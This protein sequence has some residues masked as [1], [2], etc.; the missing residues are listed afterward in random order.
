MTGAYG[1]FPKIIEKELTAMQRVA[2]Y[3]R[4]STDKNDQ[5]N[6]L[7]SQK[8]YFSEYIRQN[9]MW[10]LTE[11]YVDEGIT[12]TSTKRRRAFN[13]M[14]A[15][16]ENR[17][18]DLLLTKEISRFAR[19]TLD[20]IYY[21][22]RL[23]DWGVG[24]IFL[25]DNINTLDPD[26]ELRLTI[27]S[28]IA[29]EESRKTS[30]R[31]KWGQ[32]RRMEQ[33]VVFGRSLLGY[34]VKNGKISVNEAGAD[35]VRQIYHKF[36]VE[37]KSANRIARELQ[38]AGVPTFHDVKRWSGT[39]ILRALRNEKYCGDLVQKKTFTPDYLT[40]EK[41]RNRGEEEL[42]ILRGHH[43][44]IVSRELWERAQ[45]ELA[46]R[47][48]LR[49]QR[50]RFSSRYCFSGKLRCG[51]CGAPFVPRAKRRKDGSVYRAWRCQEAAAHGKPKTDPAGNPTGCN[52]RQ[53]GHEE[54]LE[55]M[56]R[57]VGS[58]PLD[59][60]SV[61]RD[62]FKTIRTALPLSEKSEAAE[63]LQNRMRRIADKKQR[64]ID[65]YLAGEISRSDYLCLLDQYERELSESAADLERCGRSAPPDGKG[66]FLKS[67]DAP[68]R[69]MLGGELPD[70]AFFRVLL[71]RIVLYGR[72]R[73]EI[74]LKSLPLPLTAV[75]CGKPA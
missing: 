48:P 61:L 44:P 55:L 39:V 1:R 40:H 60:E 13:R 34:D 18:F 15:D 47:S 28:S 57:A 8:R 5:I 52:N 24:V 16:A 64:L 10:Q 37:Q 11:I 27:M 29:Q 74:S 72:D 53:I 31:V 3:C 62:L 68:L 38:E 58:L 69:E 54:L 17:R 63:T 30:D 51:L 32:K 66:N 19:N 46:L 41:K 59:R 14:I 23:R 49:E 26:A 36:A 70:E 65:G 33:G 42:V 56:C 45:A 7:E 71:D 75:P 50:S 43:P 4:V 35:I 21:T 12:G 22:R 9:P 67:L 2:A 73:I 6:S 20:S 25:R